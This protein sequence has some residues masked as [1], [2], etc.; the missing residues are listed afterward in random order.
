MTYQLELRFPG[1]CI[2]ENLKWDTRVR[3]LRA[4]LCKV[5]YMM[6]TKEIMGPYMINT[7]HSNFQSCLTYGIILW[8]ENNES[9]KILNCKLSFE[10]LVVS[11]I[12]FKDYNTLTLSSLYILLVIC[13]IKNI[14]IWWQKM[15][16]SIITTCEEN[17][18]YMYNIA[19]QFPLRKAR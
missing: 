10:E 13:F 6:N 4:K 14:K 16:T 2:M 11:V 1:I 17:Y 7:F 18:I 9:N 19:I 12:I 15:W 3:L 8:G 5:V